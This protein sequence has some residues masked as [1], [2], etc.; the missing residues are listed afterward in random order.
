MSGGIPRG[1]AKSASG[2]WCC[3]AWTIV[4]LGAE[5]AAPVPDEH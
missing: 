1:I 2:W 3:L 5:I 4:L